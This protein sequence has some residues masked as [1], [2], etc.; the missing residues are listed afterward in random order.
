VVLLVNNIAYQT[1]LGAAGVCACIVESMHMYPYSALVAKWGCRAASVLAE[2]HESNIAKLGMMITYCT[3]MNHALFLGC[4]TSYHNHHHHLLL[5]LSIQL[6]MHLSI[7]AP[8]Y[9]SIINLSIYHQSIYLSIYASIYASLYLSIHLSMHLSMHLSIYK[10]AAGACYS[11]PV[12]ACH[13]MLITAP[14]HTYLSIYVLRRY[15]DLSHHVLMMIYQSIS[16][17][18]DDDLSIYLIMS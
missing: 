1:K 3:M 15:I 18:L 16:S 5:C 17:C 9:L 13:V 14:T 2:K 12:S 8:I 4:D 11:I 6:S 7:F 10:G